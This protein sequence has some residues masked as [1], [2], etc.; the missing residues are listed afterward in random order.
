MSTKYL[1]QPFDIHGGGRDL[2]FPHHENE[3]AQSEGAFGRPLAR[4]WIH[5]G[6]LNINHEKMSKSLGNFFTI[7]EILEAADPLALRHYFL[8]SHYRSPMDFSQEGLEEASKATDRIFETLERVRRGQRQ[9][10]VVAEPE[11]MDAF[12]QEMDD[13]FN[14]PRAMALMFDEVRSINR[15][16]D[17]KKARGLESR[18]A[19][20]SSMCAVL[21]LGG[22]GYSERKKERFLKKGLVSLAQIE[23]FIARRDAARKEKNWE[24]ADSIREALQE[25]GVAIEDTPEGTIWKVK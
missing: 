13:D 14:T 5:N 20:L 24:E 1:G 17:Q 6:F 3:I 16:L 12:R 9:E 4:Y 7:G 22:E 10:T 21:G 25:K 8:S 19:A 2:I 18:A 11:L 23:E 15:L